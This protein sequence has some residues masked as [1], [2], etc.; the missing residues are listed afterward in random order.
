MLFN[1]P[2]SPPQKSRSL[3]I[4]LALISLPSGDYAW[5][6]IMTGLIQVKEE[7]WTGFSEGWQGYSE[8]NPKEQTCQPEEN[9]V[10]H[11]SLTQTRRYGPLC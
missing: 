10:L 11:H 7:G 8:G 2:L 9:P 1:K 3:K 4:F 6:V 5:P